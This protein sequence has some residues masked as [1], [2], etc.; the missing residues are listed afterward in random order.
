MRYY[1]YANN[2][3]TADWS[4]ASMKAAMAKAFVMHA[5]MLMLPEHIELHPTTEADLLNHPSVRQASDAQLPES[6]GRSITGLELYRDCT[7]PPM[8]WREHFRSGKRVMHY[9]SGLVV[10]CDP[11][12]EPA[13]PEAHRRR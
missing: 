13:G 10:R 7:M 1:T 5:E 9:A 12:I 2:C 11:A 3:T 6:F 8:S 4:M